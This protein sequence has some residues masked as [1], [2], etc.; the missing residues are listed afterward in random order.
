MD[1]S[2]V[3]KTLIIYICMVFGVENVVTL[4]CV[5]NTIKV[6]IVSG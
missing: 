3:Y 2:R 5:K 6:N 4:P 1:C